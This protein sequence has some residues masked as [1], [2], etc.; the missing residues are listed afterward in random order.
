MFGVV[1]WIVFNIVPYAVLYS[2]GAALLYRPVYRHFYE[3]QRL[4]KSP[5]RDRWG[6]VIRGAE[7]IYRD[8]D[9]AHEEALGRAAIAAALWPV[10]MWPLVVF[11]TAT[12]IPA[13]RKQELADIEEEKKMQRDLKRKQMLAQMEKEIGLDTTYKVIEGGV[14]DRKEQR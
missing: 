12:P 4:I 1:L 3:K 14:V 11:K 5:Q 2:L 9:K 7:P 13:A 6:D 10:T 8:H